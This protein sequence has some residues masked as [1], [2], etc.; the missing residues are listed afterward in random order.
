[1]GKFKKKEAYI[2]FKDHKPNFE[3]KLQTR[4]INPS[5]TELGRISK[6]IIQ[7]IVKSF[8]KA[9]HCNLWGNSNETYEW[10][11]KIKNKN[12]ATFIQFDMIDF[13]LP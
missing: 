10:F 12:K 9:S 7:N 6:C 5:K 13:F 1:M 3:N 4:L 8:K 2:Q 11:R